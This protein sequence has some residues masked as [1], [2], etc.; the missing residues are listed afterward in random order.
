[1][2]LG[3]RPFETM[4]SV[5]EPSKHWSEVVIPKQATVCI[6]MQDQLAGPIYGLREGGEIQ[7]YRSRI[8]FLVARNKALLDTPVNGLSPRGSSKALFYG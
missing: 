5:G 7:M 1:M 6:G 2:P 8:R 4:D 3:F